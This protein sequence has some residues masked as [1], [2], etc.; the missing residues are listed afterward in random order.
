MPADIAI[1][2]ELNE[3]NDQGVTRE[4][5]ADPWNM[6]V[7]LDYL[8]INRDFNTNVPVGDEYAE[9][10]PDSYTFD[11]R[12]DL[13]S[14]QLS[15]LRERNIPSKK[16]FG[17][18]K[19][20]ILL[21]QDE[22]IGEF[23]SVIFDN[24][25]QIVSIQSNLYGLSV[26]QIESVLTEVRFRY[27]D[28]IGQQEETP[29]VVRLAPLIDIAKIERVIRAD[30]YKKIR[31]KGSDVMLDAALRQDSLLSETRDLLLESSGVNIDITISLGRTDRTASLNE[32]AIRQTI[33]DFQQLSERERPQ[34]EITS[35]ENEEAEIDT[36]NL[37]EPRMSDRISIVVEPRTTVAH[38]YLYNTFLEAYDIR[39][40]DIRRVI[41]ARNGR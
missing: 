30:Y 1:E 22:F 9:L 40:G 16:R 8:M 29:L 10:E 27:F 28:S 6:S 23:V 35:L 41:V 25:Y 39:R 26:S 11:E 34:I 38:E 33:E 20:A 18:I 31:I 32:T 5:P 36:I 15:K 37:L 13:Y 3:V 21:Q 14:F 19:E 4:L 17:E 2:N 24:T 12:R 7:L